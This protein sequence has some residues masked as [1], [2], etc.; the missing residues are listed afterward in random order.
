MK[1]NDEARMTNDET[2]TKPQFMKRCAAGSDF[3][4]RAFLRPSIFDIRH[5]DL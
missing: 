1:T 4:I 3:V 2:M 5:F